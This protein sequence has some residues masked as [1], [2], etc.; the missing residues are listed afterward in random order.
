[1]Q[2]NLEKLSPHENST[3]LIREYT[4]PSFK[5]PRHFHEE[6]ELTYIGRKLW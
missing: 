3:Y 2:I 1:M 5:S 4:Q 6:F